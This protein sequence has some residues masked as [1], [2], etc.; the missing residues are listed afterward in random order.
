MKTKHAILFVAASLW[1]SLN[2]CV[3]QA[4]EDNWPQFLGPDARAIS[5]NANLPERWS[6]TENVAWKTDIPGRGW[7]SPVVWGNRVFLTTV[8]SE[9]K[10][11]PPQKGFFM[12]GKA[13]GDENEKCQWKV[14][15][16]DLASGDILWEKT[17]H[18]S[19]PPG[20]TH[21]K[22]SYASETPVTDGR[23]VYA[24]FGNVGVFCF[25][26]DGKPV[27]S[28]KFEPH[29]MKMGWGT[30]SSPVLHLDRLYIA[31]DNEEKSYLLALNKNSGDE[32]WR[33][34]R[35][36]KSNWST[37][38]VWKNEKRTEIVTAASGKVRSYDLDGKLLWWFK[39][40]SGITV[41][42]PY[43]DQ[44][45]LYITSGFTRDKNRPIY[46][47]RPGATDDI[48]L[49]PEKTSNDFIA[50]SKPADAPYIPTTVLD[51]GRLYVLLDRGMV[52]AFN[53]KTGETLYEP[54]KLPKGEHFTSSPWAYNGKLFCLN[55]D[56][57]TFIV[58]AGDKFEIL[59]T[60]QLAEDD[61]CMAT[62]AIV[63]DRLLIRTL[64]RIYCIRKGK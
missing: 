30:A 54:Q 41:A 50:W 42:T 39:G 58:R 6:A 18:E 34:D 48:S 19:T 8:V 28:K 1:I 45:L 27:W 9:G 17:V 46:A 59:G 11:E 56:G 55:E 35:D 21:S 3:A 53:S 52:S 38:F 22:N 43:S 23:L 64:S 25:D 33:I 29:K 57:V 31:D 15:C 49:A 26:F 63:G 14:L 44:G 7:S 10:T 37:P 12:G 24:Y 5:A 61:L 51:D 60:N 36:E 20:P 40:M 16:L 4:A 2:T 62:P 32:I 47:I 13:P